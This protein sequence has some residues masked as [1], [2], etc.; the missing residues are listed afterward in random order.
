M[1]P[2]PEEQLPVRLPKDVDLSVAGNPLEFHP[3]FVT[4]A[5]SRCGRVGRRETDTMDVFVSALWFYFRYAIGNRP[6][7]PFTDPEALYWMPAD[8]AIGGIEHATTA[9]FHDRF[10]THAL[11]KMGYIEF[12]EPARQLLAHQLVI[13]DGRKMSKS[14]GNT[15]DPDEIVEEYGADSLRLAILFVASPSK[16][17][18]WSEQGIQGCHTFLTEIWE[19]CTELAVNH[20]SG[21]ISAAGDDRALRPPPEEIRRLPADEREFI[22]EV[23][24]VTAEVTQAYDEFQFNVA[25]QCLMRLKR[26]I[27]RLRQSSS[28]PGHELLA[29]AALGRLIRMLA[30]L[31]PHLAEEAWAM[32]GG[33]GLVLVAEWPTWDRSLLALRERRVVLQ[34]DGAFRGEI[35]VPPGAGAELVRRRGLDYLEALSAERRDGF[36]AA[37]VKDWLY[38]QKER[39]DVLNCV[40]SLPDRARS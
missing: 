7:H 39:F 17:L 38:I 1:V 4:A 10:L 5:C 31:S 40:T 8:L 24:Q 19:Q 12:D 34:V 2:V 26:Q 36:D 35:E 3:G 15:V 9:Y 33:S 16:K 13:R 11:K 21:A 29:R 18:E 20:R 32:L 25:A 22:F 23:H 30:P 27:Q 14:L 6:A 37:A 28:A